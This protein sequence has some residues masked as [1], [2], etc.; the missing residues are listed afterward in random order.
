VDNDLPFLDEHQVFAA[1]PAAAVWRSLGARFGGL[2]PGAAAYAR[3]IATDP[4][5]AS[6]TPLTE[7][8]T[9]PGFAVTAAEPERR[10]ELA[11]RHRFSAYTLDFTLTPERGGTVLRARSHAEFPGFLGGVYRGLVVRS[12]AHR[13]LVRRLLRTIAS[14]AERAAA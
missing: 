14:R 4:R 6:G 9:M 7:G 8:A 3:L 10:A 2:P 11:G 5:R 1:A 13:V 12:G